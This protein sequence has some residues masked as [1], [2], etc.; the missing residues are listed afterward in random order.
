MFLNKTVKFVNKNIIFLLLLSLPAAACFT[1]GGQPLNLVEFFVEMVNKITVGDT[2]YTFLSIFNNFSILDFQN[3]LMMLFM[4]PGLFFMGI[5]FSL[6][7]RNMKYHTVSI[8]SIR[9]LLLDALFITL[10][11]GIL[12]VLLVEVV[13]LIVSGFIALFSLLGSVW[14]WF[15]LSLA[16][17]LAAYYLLTSFICYLI[18]WIPCV[19]MEG[20]KFFVAVSLSARMASKQHTKIFITVAAVMA[21]VIG[22]TYAVNLA[23][24]ISFVALCAVLN[25]LLCLYLPAYC[26]TTYFQLADIPLGAKR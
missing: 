3:P 10:P 5:I 12:F 11:A 14:L 16:V 18:C 2:S 26:Y 20:L 19:S 8:G 25:I 22:L 23:G 7:E 15:G 9:S 1:L 17:S 6:V 13:G 24:V 21:A 4:L